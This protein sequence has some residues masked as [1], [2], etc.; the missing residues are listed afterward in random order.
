MAYLTL[1]KSWRLTLARPNIPLPSGWAK[2]VQSAV[3]PVLSLAHYAIIRARGLAAK[4]LDG[5]DGSGL[6]GLDGRRGARP[7]STTVIRY[8]R[9]NPSRHRGNGEHVAA[10]PAI[11][12]KSTSPPRARALECSNALETS[13]LA[14]AGLGQQEEPAQAGKG[15]PGA[16]KPA[17][18][19]P[20]LRLG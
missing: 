14:P 16:R 3:L 12:L 20:T 9:R 15:S 6:D 10:S 4:G 19:G 18:R 5:L 1:T 17:A 11:L 13:S 2:N 8:Q 7:L